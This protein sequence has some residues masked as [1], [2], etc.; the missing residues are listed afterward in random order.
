MAAQAMRGFSGN[1]FREIIKKFIP[2]FS[3][4]LLLTPKKKKAMQASLSPLDLLVLLVTSRF[5]RKKPGS[6]VSEENAGRVDAPV[7]GFV[8]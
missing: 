4:A 2:W 5:C 8:S 6:P 3:T 7:A 1:N